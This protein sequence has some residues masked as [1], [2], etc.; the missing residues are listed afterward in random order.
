[1]V[2]EIKKKIAEKEKCKNAGDFL[3]TN[4]NNRSRKIKRYGQRKWF[5]GTNIR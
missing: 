5:N 2:K 1:M 3:Q 4:E